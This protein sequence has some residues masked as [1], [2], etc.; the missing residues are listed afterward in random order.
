MKAYF[1][2]GHQNSPTKLNQLGVCNTSEA[3]LD[4]FKIKKADNP[5]TRI[6]N[7]SSSSS[8]TNQSLLL[9]KGPRV[10]PDPDSVEL[11]HQRISSISASAA[12]MY[13]QHD[14]RIS[15]ICASV[16]SAHQQDRRISRIGPSA[17]SAH[18]QDW[19]ISRIC[20]SAGASSHVLHHHLL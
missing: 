14:R 7:S 17:G 18:Q 19:C 12:S 3:M 1:S 4:V 11:A 5:L 16:G 20:A 13:H 2:R 6:R 9:Q 15:R 10:Y 8:V